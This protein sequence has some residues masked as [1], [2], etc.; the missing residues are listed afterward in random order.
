MRLEDEVRNRF[1]RMAEALPV[2]DPSLEGIKQRGRARRV[3]RVVAGGLV[4]AVAAAGILVPLALLSPIRTAVSPA[5]GPTASPAEG[6]VSYHDPAHGFTV[7]YPQSWYR[8][9]ESLTPHLEDPNEI[10]S[11]GT[12]VLRP[13][14]PQC[15]QLAGHAM[16]YMGAGD[17]VVSVMESSGS[18]EGQYLVTRPT[19]FSLEQGYETDA[20]SCPDDPVAFTDRLIPFQDGHRFFYAY[21]ALGNGVSP[22]TRDQVL[23]ILNSLQF[24]SPAP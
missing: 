21:V 16:Q 7:T 1:R 12:F 20:M 19:P 2:A 14:S 13:G 18:L 4:A 17:A 11:L 23:R 22:E 8:A 9:T 10:L 15:A 5:Q 3:R 24:D 6:W